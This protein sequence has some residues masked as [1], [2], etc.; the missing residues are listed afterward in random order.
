V[1]F[2]THREREI[3]TMQILGSESRFGDRHRIIDTLRNQREFEGALSVEANAACALLCEIELLQV[4]AQAAD[5]FAR[6]PPG[7]GANES[8]TLL[9]NSLRRWKE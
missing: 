1:Y 7:P 5:Q 6:F 9:R 4:V 3:P 2:V 8:L